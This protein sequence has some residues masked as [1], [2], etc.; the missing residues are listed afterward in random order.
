MP[1][2]NPRHWVVVKTAHYSILGE[3]A[4]GSEIY[5]LRNV[6]VTYPLALT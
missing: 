1:A 3:M 2:G 5:Y 6:A 4:T